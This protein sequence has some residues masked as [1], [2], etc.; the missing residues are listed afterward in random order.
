MHHSLA[1]VPARIRRALDTRLWPAVYTG[2]VPVTI[3]AAH[4]PGEPV[5]VREALDLAYAPFAAGTPWGRPWETTWFRLTARVPKSMA[6][7]RVDLLVDPG[8]TD[9]G[10]GFQ[11]EGLAYDRDGVPIKGVAPRSSWVPVAATA[12]GAEDVEV[13]VE[14]AAD[15]VRLRVGPFQIVTLRFRR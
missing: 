6:G 3:E 12:S 7:R 1:D 11:C 13:Y 5:G 2:R 4:L 10:P 9:E 15:G 8:F 14:A